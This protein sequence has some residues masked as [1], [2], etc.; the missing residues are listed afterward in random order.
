MRRASAL[1]SLLLVG[2]LDYDD[3]SLGSEVQEGAPRF[4]AEAW[5][6]S[7]GADADVLA[8]ELGVDKGAGRLILRDASGRPAFERP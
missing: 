8:I 2:C 7:S 1:S 3:V 4:F 6:P 5:N